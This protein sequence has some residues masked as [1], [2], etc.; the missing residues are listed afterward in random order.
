MSF[1]SD[2]YLH[3]HQEFDSISRQIN[4]SD[5]YDEDIYDENDDDDEYDVE[6]VDG[7]E[8]EEEIS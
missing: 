6:S 3:S 5:H 4:Q 7:E 2:A 8:E 1:N